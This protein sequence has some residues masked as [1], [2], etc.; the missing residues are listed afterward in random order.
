MDEEDVEEDEVELDDG[1]YEEDYEIGED[2][3]YKD[4]HGEEEDE[5]EEIEEPTTIKI[6]NYDEDVELDDDDEIDD[7]EEE[8]DELGWSQQRIKKASL[9]KGRPARK[10]VATEHLSRGRSISTRHSNRNGSTTKENAR[11]DE[12]S[13]DENIIKKKTS[14]IRIKPLAQRILPTRRETPKHE[15]G[16]RSKKLNSKTKTRSELKKNSL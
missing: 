6:T 5:E 13:E 10:A 8:E 11:A 7:E 12:H 15:S 14:N 2:E 1:E 4:I 16:S 9:R 3:E